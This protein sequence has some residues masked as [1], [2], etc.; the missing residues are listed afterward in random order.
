M[1][2]QL[3]TTDP[4]IASKERICQRCGRDHW[5]DDIVCNDCASREGS[6]RTQRDVFW[7]GSPSDVIAWC[8][9]DRDGQ[10]MANSVRARPEDV[11]LA[12]GECVPLRVRVSYEPETET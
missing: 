10:L 5:R 6:Q 1:N 7:R 11:R 3:N 8:A 9:L 4:G 12:C 2:D